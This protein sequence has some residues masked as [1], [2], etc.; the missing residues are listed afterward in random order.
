MSIDNYLIPD[1]L[2]PRT[3]KS[4]KYNGVNVST[5]PGTSLNANVF[6]ESSRMVREDAVAV[7]FVDMDYPL[8]LVVYAEVGTYR[9]FASEL[10]GP[11][12]R[13]PVQKLQLLRYTPL[14]T[15]IIAALVQ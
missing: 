4:R 5:V 2:N 10:R 7:S 8:A 15:N 11:A 1:G 3:K 6:S 14:V 12:R 13:H 9:E